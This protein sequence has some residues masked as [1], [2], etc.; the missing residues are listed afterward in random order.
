MANIKK[1]KKN[2]EV[3]II[4]YLKPL[5]KTQMKKRKAIC[6]EM[7]NTFAEN[8]EK[9]TSVLMVVCLVKF[10]YILRKKLAL[11]ELFLYKFI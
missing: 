4:D 1:E 7:I 10:Y 3:I 11:N 2:I 6:M 5:F 8:L 9:K